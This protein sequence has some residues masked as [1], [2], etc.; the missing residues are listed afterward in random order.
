MRH[1]LSE[2]GSYRLPSSHWEHIHM[3]PGYKWELFTRTIQM[4]PL[5]NRTCSTFNLHEFLSE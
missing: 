5:H 4:I 1:D 3:V 2:I